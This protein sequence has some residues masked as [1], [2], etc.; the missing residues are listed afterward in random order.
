MGLF[1]SNHFSMKS[2]GKHRCYYRCYSCQP[3][4]FR[5]SGAESVRHWLSLLTPVLTVGYLW[6]LMGLFIGTSAV[7]RHG[8]SILT[9]AA[10]Y[11]TLQQQVSFPGW[12][13]CKWTWKDKQHGC[14][15]RLSEAWLTIAAP[16]SSSQVCDRGRACVVRCS[17]AWL[18]HQELFH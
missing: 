6:I 7:F 2:Q 11:P 5:F 1:H 8:F 15:H 10:A 12:E 9:D 4:R 13:V 14:G 17:G 18:W 16:V 3:I